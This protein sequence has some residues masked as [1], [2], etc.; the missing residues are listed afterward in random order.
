MAGRM[1]GENITVQGIQV[2]SISENGLEVKGLVPG[3]VGSSL[4][5]KLSKK[6]P[7]LT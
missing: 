1:G 6:S 5:I 2:I 3:I 7:L 4:V